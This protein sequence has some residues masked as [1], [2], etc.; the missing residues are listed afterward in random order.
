MKNTKKELAY[1]IVL[2]KI[3]GHETWRLTQDASFKNEH[4]QGTKITE[5]KKFRVDRLTG[6]I[7]PAS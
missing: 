1:Y 5:V 7:V 3:E 4:A 2:F 6:E